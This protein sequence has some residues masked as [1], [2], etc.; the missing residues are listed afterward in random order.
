MKTF[1]F[2]EVVD[3]LKENKN[4]TF[5]YTNP[6]LDR[7]ID[8]DAAPCCLMA[9]FFK[10]KGFEKGAVSYNGRNLFYNLKIIATVEGFPLAL[11]NFHGMGFNS[12]EKILKN[13]EE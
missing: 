5:D 2:S 1:Q 11:I 8:D 4:K 6:V 10:S 7:F 3:F 12:G 9:S 13:L